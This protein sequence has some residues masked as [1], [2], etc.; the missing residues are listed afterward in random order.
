MSTEPGS[1]AAEAERSE[2]ECPSLV[3][4]TLAGRYRI[5][6]EIGSGGMGTVYRAEHVHMKKALAIKVLHREMAAVEE[7]VAR[8]ERE[9]IA[10]ARIEHPNVAKATDFGRLEDGS[11]Y[12][13][14]EFVA[15]RDLS[16]LLAEG[17]LP[18]Q[19]ALYIAEQIAS[20]MEAAHAAGV[21]HRDLK[22]EN[23]LLVERD[24]DP[25][26]VKVLDFGIAKVQLGESGPPSQLTR[27]G[28]V[29]GTPEYMSPE[30]AAGA[31][32]DHRTDLYSLGIILYQML[33]GR[34]PFESGDIVSLITAQMTAPPPPL[35]DSVPER[36]RALLGRLLEKEPDARPQSATELLGELDA[37]HAQ[38]TALAVQA[39]LPQS[40]MLEAPVPSA[41]RWKPIALVAATAIGVLIV[42]A[43]LINAATR[44]ERPLPL[45]AGAFRVQVPKIATPPPAPPPPAPA[46]TAAKP[47]PS[48]AKP[49]RKTG[50]KPTKKRKTGPGGIYIP[51]PS[52]W[53]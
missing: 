7:V 27:I 11:L 30:Q 49:R 48:P 19:R 9:A 8:F 24:G 16:T 14:M 4:T 42:I 6:E 21:V 15:G 25:D 22:P 26:C 37:I 39:T 43:L 36:V 40:A 13:V 45:A 1:A 2:A 47:K 17:P 44:H 23:V 3:G 18:V 32:V 53:F 50:S 28:S 46:A 34:P 29:F 41:R 33:A 35:P 10:A 51:P 52:E 12:L 31:G 5:D 20:A 38:R